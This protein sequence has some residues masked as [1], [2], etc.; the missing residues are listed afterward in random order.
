MKKFS[1]GKNFDGF[2]S[3]FQSKPKTP[4]NH[5]SGE[6]VDF[7]N[8]D[9]NPILPESSKD[10]ATLPRE[11]TPVHQSPSL[12][13]LHSLPYIN[14]VPL[15]HHSSPASGNR[16]FTLS[17]KIAQVEGGNPLD[18]SHP[19]KASKEN[20]RKKSSLKK[21]W[22]SN[23][24]SSSQ[25]RRSKGLQSDWNDTVRKLNERNL[26]NGEVH[27]PIFIHSALGDS[28]NE[29]RIPDDGSTVSRNHEELLN[30]QNEINKNKNGSP[31]FRRSISTLSNFKSY[32]D[33]NFSST[34]K[35]SPT[36]SN[37]SENFKFRRPRLWSNNMAASSASHSPI[38]V[39]EKINKVQDSVLVQVH[40]SA[41]KQRAERAHSLESSFSRPNRIANQ[42]EQPRSVNL[43]NYFET[44]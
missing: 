25:S 41:G 31:T 39:Q 17:N 15:Y 29:V 3:A 36:T 16:L 6:A 20:N 35:K 12:S 9:I 14:P 19:L 27:K 38:F 34:S 10:D 40:N 33:N 13:P 4:S 7:H 18:L 24:F 26:R 5:L 1:F 43:Y 21:G 28:E 30:M 37:E 42:A 44:G 22:K 11:P 2:R 8:S 23:F 32:F